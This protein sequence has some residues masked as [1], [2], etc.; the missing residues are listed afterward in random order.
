M[1]MREGRRYI[2]EGSLMY[3]GQYSEESTVKSAIMLR[4][5]EVRFC[6][7]PRCRRTAYYSRSVGELPVYCCEHA[8]KF[9]YV[10]SATGHKPARMCPHNNC[11]NVSFVRIDGQLY[12]YDYAIVHHYNSICS[13]EYRLNEC[14]DSVHL[15][16]MADDCKRRPYRMIYHPDYLGY[17][18]MEH[19]NIICDR[20]SLYMEGTVVKCRPSSTETYSEYIP[21]EDD[22]IDV[23]LQIVDDLPLSIQSL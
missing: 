17:Y 8:K 9:G 6:T 14:T 7:Y 18:C 16:C 10:N 5:V 22:W 1:K 11:T 21:D 23:A 12:C 13:P 20:L 4:I 3:Y 2:R 15:E 19:C